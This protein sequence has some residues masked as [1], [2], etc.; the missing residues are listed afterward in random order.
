MGLAVYFSIDDLKAQGWLSS[1]ILRPWKRVQGKIIGIA[2]EFKLA[3]IFEWYPH[4]FGARDEKN[5]HQHEVIIQEIIPTRTGLDKLK[6][7]VT[8]WLSAI[9]G[10]EPE[11]LPRIFRK[12]WTSEDHW[13]HYP[14]EDN[15]MQN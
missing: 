5:V 12:P 11:R 14:L 13:T 8:V 7:T 9:N 15:E 3:Y 4:Q 1:D 10:T 2:L 6:S